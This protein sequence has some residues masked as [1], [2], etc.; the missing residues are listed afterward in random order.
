LCWR[1]FCSITPNDYGALTPFI[2]SLYGV[3]TKDVATIGVGFLVECSVTSGDLSDASLA[4]FE[5]VVKAGVATPSVEFL[6]SLQMLTEDFVSHSWWSL[7]AT[8]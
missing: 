7:T 3:T 6:N 5:G 2:A 4:S 8:R 1:R